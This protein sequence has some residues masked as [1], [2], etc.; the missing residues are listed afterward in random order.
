[1]WQL[2]MRATI[3]FFA[4]FPVPK[5]DDGVLYQ[6]W[7]KTYEMCLYAQMANNLARDGAGAAAGNESP[8]VYLPTEVALEQETEK[9]VRE[10]S[11]GPVAVDS[12]IDNAVDHT[13][14]AETYAAPPEVETAA[15]SP[16]AETQAPV[17]ADYQTF[18]I[19]A[20]NGAV[21]DENVQRYF[22]QKLC[23]AGIGWFF[24]TSLLIAYQE[25]RFDFYAQ[26]PNGRDKGLLQ[27]RV[28]YHPGLEW[29]NPYAEIDIFVAQMENR[30]RM[31]CSVLDMVSRHNQSDWG[32]Y[33]Q[34]YVDEVMMH[35]GGLVRIR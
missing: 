16:T 8:M 31:G 7:M 21:L 14:A 35:A 3:A 11:A 13:T 12:G 29:W 26:N 22:Y 33:S 6:Q 10:E 20:V 17:T 27:Y 9:E 28:E 23:E 24:E 32:S 19:Y 4:L 34:K 18:P 25:S 5:A 1:M 15:E 30:A 2:V